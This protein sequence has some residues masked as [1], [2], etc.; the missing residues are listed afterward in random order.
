MKQHEVY[1]VEKIGWDNQNDVFP[2]I[3]LSKVDRDRLGLNEG[4]P[5]KVYL[6]DEEI[7]VG[8]ISAVGKQFQDLLGK[9]RICSINGQLAE[10]LK[11]IVGSEVNLERNLTESEYNQFKKDCTQAIFFGFE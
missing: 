1:K 4:D 10:R 3:L 9:D 11:L 7:E 2:I 5:V 8:V 6:V